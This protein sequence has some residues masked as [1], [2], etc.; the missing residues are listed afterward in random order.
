MRASASWSTSA[1]SRLTRQC[2][3]LRPRV[4][5]GDEL[6]EAQPCRPTGV[7]RVPVVDPD[8]GRQEE[9][10]LDGGRVADVESEHLGLPAGEGRGRELPA[11]LHGGLG[12]DDL[13]WRCGPGQGRGRDL[14]RDE[15]DLG[16]V[17]EVL[18]QQQEA[19]G[20]LL[21][22]PDIGP[23]L[24]RQP[25]Q[26]G[27]AMQTRATGLAQP[28]PDQPV[29]LLHRVRRDVRAERHPR[30]GRDGHALT[31]GVVGEP[32]Q[33][34]PHE[35]TVQGAGRERVGAVGAPVLQGDGGAG[36]RP[37]E[38]DRAAEGAQVQQ[39]SSDLGGG[40]Q[41]VPAVRGRRGRARG[42]AHGPHL[43]TG[44]GPGGRRGSA[45]RTPSSRRWPPA[46]SR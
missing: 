41:G 10:A 43:L 17:G 9:A 40:R 34:A 44:R 5:R 31:V 42:G 38:H 2:S 7:R 32:A 30:L 12:D 36:L 20:H 25:R 18:V 29:A 24:V 13:E 11:Q 1:K 46:R 35:V 15:R 23:A 4:D 16:D 45:R 8:R 26:L 14:G 37:V 22:A 27:H 33:P 21:G 39:V 3:R 19:G 28:D 6:G